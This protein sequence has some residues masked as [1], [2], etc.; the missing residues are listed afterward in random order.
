MTLNFSLFLWFFFAEKIDGSAIDG[1]SLL[2]LGSSGEG[3]LRTTIHRSLQRSAL[4]GRHEARQ[5]TSQK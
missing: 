3:L 1:A 2:P 4:V 5:E